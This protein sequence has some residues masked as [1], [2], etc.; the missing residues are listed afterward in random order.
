[1]FK[2]LSRD[3]EDITKELNW[4]S[5][6]EI[7]EVKISR[8]ETIG[9]VHTAEEKLSEFE[10]L[11]TETTQNKT[12]RQGKPK[13]FKWHREWWD[14]FKQPNAEVTQ[15][16][17]TGERAAGTEKIFEGVVAKIFPNLMKTINPQIQGTPETT[18]ALT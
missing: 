13:K 4:T 15:E 1:M 10:D 8:S 5:R 12:H 11:P 14:D 2:K 16:P 9:R 7:C 17:E 3:T 18:P 6:N